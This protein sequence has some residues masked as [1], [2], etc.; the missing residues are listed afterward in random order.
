M[1]EGGNVIDVWNYSNCRLIVGEVELEWV[2]LEWTSSL[3]QRI[4]NF[5]ARDRDCCFDAK[6]KLSRMN[7]RGNGWKE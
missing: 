7:E 5:R 6:L 3:V 1:D 4:K 2:R